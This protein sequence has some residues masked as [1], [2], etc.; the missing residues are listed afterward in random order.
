MN[1]VNFLLIPETSFELYGDNGFMP[2]LKKR[3]KKRGHAVVCVAEGTGQDLLNNSADGISYD[4]SGNVVLKDIGLYLKEKINSYFDSEGMH[5]N[6]KYIDPS[7]I[8]R[9]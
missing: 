4:A 7:Y 9:S 3:M 5:I 6:L 1:D 2:Y 8:I